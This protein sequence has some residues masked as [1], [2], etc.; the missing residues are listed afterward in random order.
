M[1]DPETNKVVTIEIAG[2]QETLSEDLMEKI[3]DSIELKPGK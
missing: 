2:E 3:A 1:T